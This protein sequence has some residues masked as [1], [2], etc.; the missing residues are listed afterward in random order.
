MEEEGD[1]YFEK[2]L[3]DFTY[4]YCHSPLQGVSLEAGDSIPAEP[5]PF[6]C[7]ATEHTS[8]LLSYFWLVM[9]N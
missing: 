1:T 4:S 2:F 8:H 5:G 7:A 9:R 6:V 3:S